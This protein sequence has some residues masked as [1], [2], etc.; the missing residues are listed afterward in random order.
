MPRDRHHLV[1]YGFSCLWLT[2]GRLWHTRGVCTDRG[3][4]SPWKRM[5][6]KFCLGWN[7]SCHCLCSSREILVSGGTRLRGKGIEALEGIAGLS[8]FGQIVHLSVH[9][10]L[11]AL[12]TRSWHLYRIRRADAATC[13]RRYRPLYAFHS[14]LNHIL[15]CSDHIID[16][17]VRPLDGVRVNDPTHCAGREHRVIPCW[18]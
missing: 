18:R 4:G 5:E 15:G 12:W 9:N 10:S 3:A 11:G 1:N 8:L 6:G 16:F 2:F 13:P 17:A 7:R 14:F